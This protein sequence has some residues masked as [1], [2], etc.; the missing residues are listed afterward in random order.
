MIIRFWGTRGSVP[1]PSKNTVEFGANTSCVEVT[2]KSGQT[3][4]LDAGTGI[5]PLGLDYLGRNGTGATIHLLMSHVHW[6][7]IQGFPFFVPAY[8]GKYTI[9]LYSNYDMEDL[10]GRQMSLPFFPVSMEIMQSKE[11][12]S[13]SSIAETASKSGALR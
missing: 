4:I 9:H 6:D 10:L 5:R 1:S 13:T 11:R 2:L 3:L 12:S 7:H 8:I